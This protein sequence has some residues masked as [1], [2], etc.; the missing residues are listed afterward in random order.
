MTEPVLYS[1]RRCPYAMRARMALAASGNRVQLREVVLRDKPPALL[2]ASPKGTVPVLV[3]ADGEV[4]DQSLEIMLRVLR[5]HDPLQ[6]LPESGAEMQS[7]LQRIARCDGEFKLHLD[8]YKY[9]HRYQ[10][11]DGNTHRAQGAEFL[12]TMQDRLQAHGFLHGAHWGLADAA[13]APFVRQFAH[14]DPTWFAAQPWQ[15]LQR[16]LQTFEASEIFTLCMHKTP[17]WR[18]GEEPIFF[19]PG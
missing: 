7:S 8:R 17:A 14:T 10:L 9:P 13:I 2:A 5:S 18:E 1:F 4:V 19:P 16:W 11:P 15:A 12:T 6:W 3:L